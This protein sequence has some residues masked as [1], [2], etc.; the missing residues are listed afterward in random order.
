MK[1]KWIRQCCVCKKIDQ[2]G[3][4][5]M[6]KFKVKY[7]SGHTHFETWEIEP[8]FFCP[9]CGAKEVWSNNDDGDY[10]EGNDYLCKSCGTLWT[11][12]T[13]KINNEKDW[14]VTQRLNAIRKGQ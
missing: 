5:I 14:Q 12:P 3:L 13:F 10:Y 11:M 1:K 7:E 6:L 4:K 8:N 9:N 2:K